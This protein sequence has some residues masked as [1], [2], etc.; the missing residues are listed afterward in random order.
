MARHLERFAV[1]GARGLVAV[2]PVYLADLRARYPRA[3]TFRLG[4]HGTIPFGWLRRDFEAVGALPMGSAPESPVFVVAYVGVGD[5]VMRRSF[6]RLV[7]GLARL[8][9]VAPDIVNKCRIR[10]AGTRGGWR[11]GDPKVLWNEAQSAG[12]GDLVDEDPRI[13]SYSDAT[14]IALAADG[15]LVLGVDDPAYMPSKLFPYA[16]T[17]KPLLACMH[18]ESQANDYFRRFP[19]LGTIIH[20]GGSA[21]A[22]EDQRL[23]EFMCQVI[24]RRREERRAVAAEHSAE[25]MT[26]RHVELFEAC[27]R[28]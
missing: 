2:S 11:E 8:R 24:S 14:S 6:R 20:F 4:T 17:G 7:M 22:E 16:L 25:T 18:R 26:R 12:V 10:L 3:P 27:L 5:V 28:H 19:D 21:T 23:L 9:C 1:M 13:I 15:L